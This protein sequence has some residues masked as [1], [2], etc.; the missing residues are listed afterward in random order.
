VVLLDCQSTTYCH[1]GPEMARRGLMNH[2]AAVSESLG[3][4]LALARA[5][6]GL[7]PTMPLEQHSC[8]PLT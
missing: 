5:C 7:V 1:T 8:G 2:A 6:L 3:R 4:S